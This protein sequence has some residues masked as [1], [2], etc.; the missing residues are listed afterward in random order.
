MCISSKERW[1]SDDQSYARNAFCNKMPSGMKGDSL[2]SDCA[3]ALSRIALIFTI[4]TSCAVLC[5]ATLALRAN[6]CAL[7]GYILSTDLVNCCFYITYML[8]TL[9]ILS[10]RWVQ[11]LFYATI[12]LKVKHTVIPFSYQRLWS[13]HLSL[14]FSPLV[15]TK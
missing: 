4:R 3:S 2:C 14:S 13:K 8:Y 10:V 1:R 11:I 6:T 9:Y 5:C 7:N 12:E 15:I